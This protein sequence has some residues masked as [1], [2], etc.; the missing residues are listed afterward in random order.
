MSLPIFEP[1]SPDVKNELFTLVKAGM[2][3]VLDIKLG[4]V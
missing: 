4:G 3:P 2:L 1:W